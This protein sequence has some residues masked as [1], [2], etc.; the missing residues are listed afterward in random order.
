MST[1]FEAYVIDDDMLAAVQRTVRG[2]EVT[3]ETLAFDMIRD[4]VARRGPLPGPPRDASAGCAAT[5]STRRWATARPRSPGRPAERVDVRERARER[6]RAVLRSHYPEHIS[7]EL[8]D[9]IRATFD[10]R[11]PREAMRPGNGRWS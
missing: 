5:S 10:I 1:A 2:I 11:L 9:R 6:V 8:D 4:V 7:P 3:D